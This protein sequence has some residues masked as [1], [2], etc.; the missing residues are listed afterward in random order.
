MYE[1]GLN[2]DTNNQIKAVDTHMIKNSEWDAI[3]YLTHSKYG[4]N[5]RTVK[6]IVT[7]TRVEILIRVQRQT[8]LVC[9]I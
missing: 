9:L 5:G 6:K 2:L 4:L 1:Q 3:A 7:L 8:S